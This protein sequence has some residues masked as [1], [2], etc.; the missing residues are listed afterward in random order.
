MHFCV[1]NHSFVVVVLNKDC[2][3]EIIG[4]WS[5]K[6]QMAKNRWAPNSFGERQW[7]YNLQCCVKV[8]GLSVY[9]N[10]SITFPSKSMVYLYFH[11]NVIDI[12]PVPPQSLSTSKQ[13]SSKHMSSWLK[14][15]IFYNCK[16][17]LWKKN[18]TMTSWKLKWMTRLFT[19]TKVTNI[20]TLDPPMKLFF[21]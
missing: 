6:I 12:V 4:F 1:F 21:A 9:G 5:S 2:C 14:K 10:S 11:E 18:W 15:I 19:S 8:F 7:S 3:F 20:L 16:F 13:L 17:F